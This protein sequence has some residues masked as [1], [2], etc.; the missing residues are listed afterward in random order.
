MY[1]AYHNH[2]E[3]AQ[4]LI[5]AGCAID[6]AGSVSWWLDI[7]QAYPEC[8][9]LYPQMI[10]RERKWQNCVFQNDQKTMYMLFVIFYNMHMC[11]VHNWQ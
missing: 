2:P 5:D 4:A 1:A 8:F 11:T 10:Q 9:K 7:S 6:A 3:V